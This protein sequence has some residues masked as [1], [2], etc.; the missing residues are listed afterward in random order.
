VCS[1]RDP[2]DDRR[3]EPEIFVRVRHV[4]AAGV[5]LC[6]VAAGWMVAARTFRGQQIAQR[7]A[8]AVVAARI[9]PVGAM[10]PIAPNLYAVQ[11]GGSTSTIF[12]ASR[13]VLIVDTKYADAWDALLAEIRKVTD[14]PVT[15]VVNTHRHLD[16]SEGNARLPAGVQVV[17][18]A[19]AGTIVYPRDTASGARTVAAPFESRQTLFEGGDAVDLYHFG[20]AHTDGDTLVVFRSA[21]VLAA[22][23]VM[24]GLVLPV[25]AIEH[26]GNGVAYMATL[27]RA[28]AELPP[29]EHVV[30]GHGPVVSWA[31]FTDFAGL[32]KFL[33]DYV[34]TNMHIG[35]DKNK[36]FRALRV[37]ERYARFDASRAF[38]TLDEMDRS[39][40]PRWKRLLNR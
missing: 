10:Q 23:D 2:R 13:G 9:S 27:E 18:Q 24:E 26:G 34:R 35:A 7:R 12:V 29:I 33:L 11:G 1:E 14:K 5:T 8:A 40:R 3:G 16:H 19:N 15:H 22:G 17:A 21:R 30:T 39:L 36:T 6:V 38:A 4:V 37:P 32:T 28:M 31:D 20:P 25:M